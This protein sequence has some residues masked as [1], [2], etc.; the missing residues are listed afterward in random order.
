[1]S[2]VAKHIVEAYIIHRKLIDSQTEEAIEAEQ[3]EGKA[4]P[5]VPLGYVPSTKGRPLTAVSSVQC[6]RK[7]GH[8]HG[9][10]H[11]ESFISGL[12]VEPDGDDN[13]R[14]ITWLELYILYR[15]RGGVKP[16]PDDAHEAVSKAT[17]DKQL[18]AFKRKLRAVVERTL[19]HDG[20]AVLFKPTKG[21]PNNLKGCGILGKL[22][23]VS[24]NVRIGE[25]E[26]KAIALALS[27]LIRTASLRK[28]ND[29]INGGLKLIPLPLKL[30][31]KAK[32]DS[33]I[34]TL[35]DCTL[36]ETQ[37]AKAFKAGSIKPTLSAMFYH[38]PKCKKVESSQRGVFQRVDLDFKHR[39]GFCNKSTAVN[40]WTCECNSP[41]H[42]CVKHRGGYLLVPEGESIT[43]RLING[44]PSTFTLP[45][46]K[47]TSKKRA[48][49]GEGGIS[50]KPK[51]CKTAAR[52]VK[53]RD[54]V[55]LSETQRLFKRSCGL[56]PVFNGMVGGASTSP[57]A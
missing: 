50:G 27:K 46:P 41:W 4:K 15:L 47:P 26:Q 34:P 28:H 51:R 43:A 17:A 19:A 18:R 23:T 37:W 56:G 45:A 16:I 52:G 55:T 24:F 57:S 48:C 49:V 6:Y 8:L 40:T 31:G 42:S 13:G 35:S 3:R 30:K 7:F 22:P 25:D 33:T 38:C 44:Q 5:Y 10:Q 14:M 54:T 53:R 9:I 11:I 2:K 20:D 36:E 1:M 12:Q 32:W 29:F 21:K 39:C